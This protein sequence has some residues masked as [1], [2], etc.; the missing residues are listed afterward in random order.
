MPNQSISNETC[1]RANYH[2]LRLMESVDEFFKRVST[3]EVVDYLNTVT[4]GYMFDNADMQKD[5]RHLSD[6]MQ[7]NNE[8]VLF[9]IKLSTGRNNFE[10]SLKLMD[11]A[12]TN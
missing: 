6:T 4:Q 12:G 2:A 5:M 10:T 8:L 9:M 1:H 7:M 3:E 11:H